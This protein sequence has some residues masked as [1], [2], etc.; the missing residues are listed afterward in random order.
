[1]KSMSNVVGQCLLAGGLAVILAGCASSPSVAKE[2]IAPPVIAPAPVSAFTPENTGAE[3][4]GTV[5]TPESVALQQCLSQAKQ[6]SLMR[7]GKYR[8]EVDQV[9]RN[10]KDAKEYAV[11]AH[12]TPIWMQDILTPLHRYVVNDACNQVSQLMLKELRKKVVIQTGK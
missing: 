2:N 7:N 5:S 8:R 9:Y 1:M 11:I 12:D 3:R 10:I 4:A 6:L